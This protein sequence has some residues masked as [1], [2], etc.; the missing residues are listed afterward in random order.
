MLPEGFPAF[1][2]FLDIL[3]RKT[4]AVQNCASV[5][6]CFVIVQLYISLQGKTKSLLSM[7]SISDAHTNA[8]FTAVYCKVGLSR[9]LNVFCSRAPPVWPNDQSATGEKP[10]S[11]P[12]FFTHPSFFCI[13]IS[14]SHSLF[15][16]EHF[17]KTKAFLCQFIFSHICLFYL[18][19]F[20]SI[21]ILPH[22]PMSRNATTSFHFC[23]HLY[24]MYI[25]TCTHVSD[26]IFPFVHTRLF[27]LAPMCRD[28]S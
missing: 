16:V 13:Q 10:P 6:M 7:K 25:Y 12:S 28:T 8:M 21:P 3:G 1:L 14:D 18:F 17:L 15:I 4:C 19:Y 23:I 11:P 22:Q 27:F 26:N 5:Q 9:V 2:Q 24:S 20:P